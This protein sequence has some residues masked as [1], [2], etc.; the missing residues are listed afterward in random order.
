M[1]GTWGYIPPGLRRAVQTWQRA[2]PAVLLAS[3]CVGILI[4]FVAG[5]VASR[6]R[7]L[8]SAQESTANLA[9]SL[10][11]HAEATLRLGDLTT[12]AIVERI[13]P[14][15][16]RRADT[17]Q[18]HAYLAT[19]LGTAGRVQDAML[20]DA[21]GRFVVGAK[22]AYADASGLT[23]AL[24][25]HRDHV[26]ATVHV[27]P[28]VRQW[29]ADGWSI[30]LSRRLEAA[31]GSFAG[32][33]VVAIDLDLFS[34]A[35]HALNVGPH[36]AIALT[37]ANGQ[38]LVRTRVG[39]PLVGQDVSNAAFFRSY[40]DHGPV[41][42]LT[43]TSALDG[44]RRQ[45]SY[46]AVASYPLVVFVGLSINDVLD[47]WW[48]DT[49]SNGFVVGLLVL[50]TALLGARLGRLVRS[51]RQAAAAA[52]A[53]ERLYRL[54]AV[55]G[56]DV[57][58][59]LGTDLRRRYVSPASLDVLGYAP[60]A[61]LGRTPSEDVHPEDREVLAETFAEL[62]GS[63]EPRSVSVRFRRADGVYITVEASIRALCE[64]NGYVVSLRDVSA[65]VAVQAK[66]HEANS[67]LQRLVMLD[68]LTGIANRRC[69]DKCLEREF[70]RA[71][72]EEQPLAV[73]M[74]DADR[75]KSY[76]DTYGH[77]A[78]DECL[79]AIA[80]VVQGA[81]RRAA[82][83][84]A[85]FGGEEFC[86]M[87][88]HTDED[89]AAALAEMIRA[90]VE[91]LAIPHAGSP[92]GTMTISVGVGVAHPGR[93]AETVAALMAA[94]DGALYV[95]KREGRNNVKRSGPLRRMAAPVQLEPMMELDY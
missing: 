24:E 85:R 23:E 13:Q 51:H 18:L 87:L 78:G 19:L 36:G 28:P 33:A 82:D 47:D 94:A 8:D 92:T 29:V 37:S 91:A 7:D 48:R 17:A 76:N 6:A 66:L 38:L 90:S 62:R 27:S 44:I 20:F 43:G 59:Q 73:L 60:E 35:Y 5:S 26:L 10:A 9:R 54:L 81:M 4:A 89:G 70:R 84:A 57:I 93:D 3:V 64:E 68:G 58:V 50:C 80:G 71:S 74:I 12:A 63:G 67:R 65:R 25:W 34:T 1:V 45:G 79:K 95:A 56:T 55:N 69:L 86:V 39:G 31:D 53:S 46:R 2:W 40:A 42:V 14:D 49:A 22:A 83:L 77:Q 61:L 15:G 52:Q 41:G 72:R 30:L 32:V 11:D 21:Q 88:P 75:F 16:L